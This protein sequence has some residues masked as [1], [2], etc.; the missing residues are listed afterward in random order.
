VEPTAAALQAGEVDRRLSFPDPLEARPALRLARRLLPPR[1]HALPRAWPRW[2]GE[3]R[4]LRVPVPETSWRQ[5]R[6]SWLRD[7]CV[8]VG[9]P[10]GWRW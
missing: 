9:G 2:A 6:A 5:R 3:A 1:R 7:Q 8:K 10:R 4:P